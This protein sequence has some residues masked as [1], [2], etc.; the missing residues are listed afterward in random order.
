MLMQTETKG[1][2][3]VSVGSCSYSE[4][5][6]KLIGSGT[7]VTCNLVCGEINAKGQVGLV[8]SDDKWFVTADDKFFIVKD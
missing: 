8:T 3:T 4:I 5:D 1:C 2:I 7:S 6:A